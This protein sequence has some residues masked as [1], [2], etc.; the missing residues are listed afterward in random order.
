MAGYKFCIDFFYNSLSRCLNSKFHVSLERRWNHPAILL[1]KIMCNLTCH[2]AI[3]WSRLSGSLGHFCLED[4]IGRVTVHADE[5]SRPLA[6]D[7]LSLRMLILPL[8]TVTV[9]P[10]SQALSKGRGPSSERFCFKE[11][12]VNRQIRERTNH[13]EYHVTEKF[14]AA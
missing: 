7:S 3:S 10:S 12:G 11:Q 8:L 1:G 13:E 6:W 9:S 2:L 4:N 5:D 14:S